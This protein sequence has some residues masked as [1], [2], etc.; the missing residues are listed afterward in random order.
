[1]VDKYIS[2]S[3]PF[4][5]EDEIKEVIDSLR[6]GWLTSGPKVREFES[7]VCDYLGSGYGVAVFS[8]TSAMFLV[9]RSLGI[10]KGDEVIVP[11]FTFASTAHVV[12]H[13]GATPVFVDIDPKTLQMDCNK[14]KNKITN[15]TKAIIAVH[16]GGNV[17]DMDSLIDTAKEHNLYIIEDAAH[18]IG[19]EYRGNKIGTLDSDATC[20]SFYATKNIVTAEGGMVIT[21]NLS[22][23]NEV[24]KLSRYGI[25]DS[26]QI[27]DNRYSSKPS[28][29]YDIELIGYKANMTDLNAA[30]GLHQI[31][32]LDEFNRIRTIY[33]GIYI[34][35]L[36]D[37]EFIKVDDNN[38]SSWHL[39]PLLLPV[40]VNRELFISEL[41]NRGIGT[42]VL[43]KP[44]HL[45]TA[46]K[47]L[48]NT[49]AGDYP[50]SESVY[51]RLINLPISPAIK[52]DDIYYISSVVKEV[53]G[54]ISY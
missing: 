51:N 33:S 11:T 23:A 16:Y 40:N 27:W 38:K 47:K 29:D 50:V 2:F 41:G 35:E 31:K 34:S 37:L 22:L 49:K 8:C 20:F 24:R 54:D 7:L 15:R 25:S 32:R 12:V 1:M 3:P 28:W 10:K 53:L 44:L 13:C 19:S 36:K 21:N 18:A 17:V 42:S 39:F 26:R 30:I 48:L 43:F 6:S 52:K 46:Y 4:I 14:V 9:L 5:G 45:H